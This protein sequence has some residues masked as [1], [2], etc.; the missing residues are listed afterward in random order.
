MCF[1]YLH[2]PPSTPPS[3]NALELPSEKHRPLLR[4]NGQFG[5]IHWQ[6][7]Y[8]CLSFSW[9]LGVYWNAICDFLAVW[10]PADDRLVF[11]EG[12]FSQTLTFL[13]GNPYKTSLAAVT[14][15]VEHPNIYCL[16]IIATRSIW[17]QKFIKAIKHCR[18]HLRLIPC[19]IPY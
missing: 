15:E 17:V 12:D 7:V 1:L 4:G 16:L 2:Y 18:K 13:V 10:T 8:L 6:L 9:W 3:S 19:W 5:A 14:R 11:V